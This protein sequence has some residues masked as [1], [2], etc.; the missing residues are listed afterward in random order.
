MEPDRSSRVVTPRYQVT[1]RDRAI[2]RDVWL[3]RYLTAAQASRLHFGHLKL[4]QRRLRKLTSLDL[5]FRFRLPSAAPFG[6]QRWIYA[7]SRQ[8]AREVA[9][10]Q[11]LQPREI[12]SPSHAPGALAYIAHH[13]ALTDARIW[14]REACV[15]SGVSCRFVP[16]YEEVRGNGHPRRRAALQV[17][18]SQYIPDG[19]FTLDNGRG[20]SALFLLEIDRGTEPLRR[21]TGSSVRTKLVLFR[22]AFDEG[23]AGYT[24]LFEYQFTGARLLWVVPDDRRQQ[25]VLDLAAEEDLSPLVWATVCRRMKEPGSLTAAVWS[26]AG[27]VGTHALAA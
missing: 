4:A 25:A 10:D 2:L 13:E 1:D 20:R 23:L 17:G 7:L 6:D 18:A 8:G 27:Q 3:F 26:V 15:A 12:L 5:M 14:I 21:D 9:R 24:T 22:E 19:V 11:S 16:A